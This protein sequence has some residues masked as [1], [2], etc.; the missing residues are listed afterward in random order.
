MLTNKNEKNIHFGCKV[1]TVDIFILILFESFILNFRFKGWN[2]ISLPLYILLLLG[3]N[4]I[5]T[6]TC[7]S[8]FRWL[9]ISVSEMQ[10]PYFFNNVKFT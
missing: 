8:I 7:I 9:F 2:Q 10:H 4:S 3:M 6:L 5:H 1:T